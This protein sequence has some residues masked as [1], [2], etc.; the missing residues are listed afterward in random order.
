MEREGPLLHLAEVLQRLGEAASGRRGAS[1]GTS[2]ESVVRGQ[3][4]RRAAQLAQREQML[5]NH[6]AKQMLSENT[7]ENKNAQKQI[8]RNETY[9][10]PAA[11]RQ[12]IIDAISLIP[13]ADLPQWLL[14]VTNIQSPQVARF[15]ETVSRLPP[16]LKNNADILYREASRLYWST[17]WT[18]STAAVV[19]ETRQVIEGTFKQVRQ[20]A[21]P[22][23]SGFEQYR[24]IEDPL[25]WK[26]VD[27]RYDLYRTHRVAGSEDFD[28]VDGTTAEQRWGSSDPEKFRSYRL[29]D[30]LLKNQKYLDK[31]ND[32]V[33]S[34]S[35]ELRKLR[36]DLA[37]NEDIKP[38]ESS[39]N[40]GETNTYIEQ[41]NDHLDELKAAESVQQAAGGRRAEQGYRG[42]DPEQ[43]Q[44]DRE[45]LEEIIQTA[46]GGTLKHIADKALN[47]AEHLGQQE[48]ELFD[49]QLAESEAKT[50]QYYDELYTQMRQQRLAE[51]QRTNPGAT[52]DDVIIKNEELHPHAQAERMRLRKLRDIVRRRY[53][54][55]YGDRISHSWWDTVDGEKGRDFIKKLDKIQYFAA[56]R[57]SELPI[58]EGDPTIALAELDEIYFSILR[59]ADFNPKDPFREAINLYESA[60]LSAFMR[61]LEGRLKELGVDSRRVDDVLTRYTSLRNAKEMAHNLIYISRIGDMEMLGKFVGSLTADEIDFMYK[62]IPGIEFCQHIRESL[63]VREEA[64]YGCL[65][66]KFFA[67]DSEHGGVSEWDRKT[68][69]LLDRA[70]DGKMIKDR[71]G[72]ERVMKSHQRRNAVEFSLAIDVADL[73][74]SEMLSRAKGATDFASS[75]R[76]GLSIDPI[77][78]IFIKFRVKKPAVYMLYFGLTGDWQTA[79]TMMQG[80][81]DVDQILAHIHAL[82]GDEHSVFGRRISD[83]RNIIDVGGRWGSRSG[84]GLRRSGEILSQEAYERRGVGFEANDARTRITAEVEQQEKQKIIKKLGIGGKEL[85]GSK[86]ATEIQRKMAIRMQDHDV[87]K[88]INEQVAEEALKVMEKVAEKM[89]LVIVRRMAASAQSRFTNI[90]FELLD[91]VLDGEQV[92]ADVNAQSL[93]LNRGEIRSFSDLAKLRGENKGGERPSPENHL[94]GTLNESV[95]AAWQQFQEQV[96]I[97]EGDLTLVQQSAVINHHDKILDSDYD[98]IDDLSGRRENV[99]KYVK[100]IQKAARNNDS[101][102]NILKEQGTESY[103][104]HMARRI[105]NNQEKFTYTTED[106]IYSEFEWVRMGDRGLLRGVMDASSALAG[107]KDG[108]MKYFETIT[109]HPNMEEVV[110]TLRKDVFVP[111]AGYD[112][113]AAQEWCYRMALQTIRYYA[114]SNLYSYSGPIGDFLNWG[115]LQNQF[116]RWGKYEW[117]SSINRALADPMGVSWGPN[118]RLKFIHMLNGLNVLAKDSPI[119]AYSGHNFT[120]H[121]LENQTGSRPRNVAGEWVS[122]GLIT[123]PF[124]MA[125]QGTKVS[126]EEEERK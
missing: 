62:N 51:L 2:K 100:S 50:G 87:V 83:M 121:H 38:N 75:P 32:D 114:E 19:H 6:E 3:A 30:R 58:H 12:K 123:S 55:R 96:D 94:P 120:A 40:E 74:F 26:G 60:D 17:D 88:T 1:M 107:A 11:D 16:E 41:I 53:L 20:L 37:R 9:D 67:T 95:E 52:I 13:I 18:S 116:A 102:N 73:R 5:A 48:Y 47:D 119:N 69:D 89:P 25:L 22:A 35:D 117:L 61:I 111:I 23:N 105:A 31:V 122:Y 21:T 97:L 33:G 109:A 34:Q 91:Q 115:L 49:K 45:A 92:L 27:Y 14:E 99:K 72:K 103:L 24:L 112:D 29:H 68:R 93:A 85:E 46:E 7:A 81:W 106:A 39:F 63:L 56:T 101:G 79:R 54:E 124:I 44:K 59:P 118:E 86:Y 42:A 110:G 70:L 66:S 43:A 77:Q 78:G 90:R 64:D 36:D 80:K 71:S 98:V 15:Y 125:W 126:T 76:E 108:M 4:A 28:G 82:E 8:A 10:I 57:L 104:V 113:T 65:R 84:W